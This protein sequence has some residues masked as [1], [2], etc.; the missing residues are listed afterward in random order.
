MFC[1]YDPQEAAISATKKRINNLVGQPLKT[2]E[3]F[4]LAKLA[5]FLTTLGVSGASHPFLKELDFR[6]AIQS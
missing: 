4:W 3:L 2:M 5:I 1:L 6:K